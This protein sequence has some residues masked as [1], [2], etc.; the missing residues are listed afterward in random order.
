MYPWHHDL[1]K[2]ANATGIRID[3][4]GLLTLLGAEEIDRSVGRLV[5]SPYLDYL[6]LL[7]AFTVAG[8]HFTSKQSGF[9]IYNI[10]D[11]VMT[12]EL[13]G[14]FSRWLAGQE[15]HRVRSIVTW[16][17]AERPPQLIKI[18]IGLLLIALPIHG[19][20][21]ALTVLAADWWGFANVMA[22]LVSVIVRCVLVNENRAAIDH[23]I[24][25][26]EDEAME[27]SYPARRAKYTEALS[28]LE[29]Q[30]R[31]GVVA[32]GTRDPIEPKDPEEIVK[33]IVVTDDSKAVT[34]AAP[35]KL[36]KLIFATNP[37][38]PDPRIYRV[39][40]ALGWAAFAVH[41]ISIGMAQLYTQIC[42][43]VVIIGATILTI[44]KV[45]CADSTMS[46]TI[47]QA[48]GSVS[49]DDEEYSCW[50]SSKLKA[51]VSIYPVEFGEW[52]EAEASPNLPKVQ[53]LDNESN[54][55]SWTRR[56]VTV[57]D[58]ENSPPSPKPPRRD[59]GR[60]DLYAWL[61]LTEEE[62]TRLKFWGMIPHN[63][64]W[65]DKYTE[66]KVFHGRRL[67]RCKLLADS[68]AQ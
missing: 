9:T 16:K 25:K 66:K 36:A 41:V 17:V 64:E 3:A 59:P 30:R 47:L 57:E 40:K 33:M 56:R 42:T 31:R 61:D 6:P 13:A 43:V 68:K 37:R 53:N 28:V 27:Y 38:P 15:F 51:T 4:L 39:F 50:I 1:D 11:G 14:W 60:Q 24:K 20:L 49:E 34:I 44:Y 5:P 63:P 62:D 65:L 55:D 2:W 32:E 35:R 54:K 8:G 58:L 10:S 45:G 52:T 26:V 12:T 21:I 46:H 23:N 29:D 7:G 22:M 67:E 48:I 19:M 18:G